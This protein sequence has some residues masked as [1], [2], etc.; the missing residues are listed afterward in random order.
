MRTVQITL[1]EKLINEVDREA[2]KMNTSRSALTREALENYLKYLH[3]K[4]MEKNQIEGYKNFPVM[5]NEM[6]DW[7][8]EQ[9]WPE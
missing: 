4:E 2:R 3:S 8:N 9:V 6:G 7:E 1:D 5:K